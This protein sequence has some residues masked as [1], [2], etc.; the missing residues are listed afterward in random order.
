MRAWLAEE[1]TLRRDFRISFLLR[2]ALVE[3]FDDAAD[4]VQEAVLKIL[5][6][7]VAVPEDKERRDSTFLSTLVNV[8]RDHRKAARI[9][10]AIP[11]DDG[12]ASADEIAGGVDRAWRICG[13]LEAKQWVAD[14]LDRLTEAE[15]E[16]VE[17]R[18]LR[19][20]TIAEIAEHRG[21]APQTVRN[22]LRRALA[23]SRQEMGGLDLPA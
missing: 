3:D 10:R 9:R 7:K 18:H 21:C 22:L 8:A 15:R 2:K 12:R 11:I 19:E 5:E 6:H 23:K 13:R 17:L 20:W 1:M 16:V 14:A 4:I